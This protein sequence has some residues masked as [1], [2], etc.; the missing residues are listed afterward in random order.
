APL[1]NPGA[2]RRC[3]GR[4]GRRALRA[5]RQVGAEIG[6]WK[7]KNGER[8]T[9]NDQFVILGSR[10]SVL[11]SSFFIDPGPSRATKRHPCAQELIRRP[12][13]CH[14]PCARRPPTRGPSRLGRRWF[15]C[16]PTARRARPARKKR[17]SLL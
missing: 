17:I 13:C 9:E 4:K 7:M 16:G 8:R 11:R 2:W 15:T 14:W 12:S 10:F 3:E 1:R 6:V 5:V